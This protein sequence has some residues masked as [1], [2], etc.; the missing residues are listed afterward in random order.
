MSNNTR[1]ANEIV[2]HKAPRKKLDYAYN[3]YVV[4]SGH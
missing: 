1:E 2:Q 3:I 4:V